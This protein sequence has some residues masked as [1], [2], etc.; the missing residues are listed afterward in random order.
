MDFRW[1]SGFITDKYDYMEKRLKLQQD[2]ERLT[3]EPDDLQAAVDLLEN[4]RGHFDACNGDIEAQHELIKLIVARVYVHDRKVYAITL[5]SD[6]HVLLGHDGGEPS[7]TME[8]DMG[9]HPTFRRGKR[10]RDEF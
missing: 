7:P 9:I 1:D 3:P 4:F 8:I 5:K 6:Y 10:E 2:L